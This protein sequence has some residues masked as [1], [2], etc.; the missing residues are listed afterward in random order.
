MLIRAYNHE[1]DEASALDVFD[2]A[3]PAAHPFLGQLEEFES[4]RKIIEVQLP[5]RT[6]Y[7]AEDGHGVIGF[8]IIDKEGY[9]PALYV[10]PT[11]YN[12]GA[13][14]ALLASVQE[15]S[16]RLTLHVFEDNS[17]AVGFYRSKGFRIVDEDRAV[18]G[19][20]RGHY[21]LKMVRTRRS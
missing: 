16:Q 21:R 11:K 19:L 4:A 18:D 2:R 3:F 14:S 7:L 8:I 9:I 15:L 20:G 10:L 17:P 1:H 13:G 12:K 5:V 6:V